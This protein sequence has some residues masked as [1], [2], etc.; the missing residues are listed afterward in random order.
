MF[1]LNIIK[2]I[3]NLSA[4]GEMYKVSNTFQ[5]NINVLFKKSKYPDNH[6]FVSRFKPVPIYV[7]LKKSRKR[8]GK[9]KHIYAR[10]NEN[11]QI[12]L[13]QVYICIAKILLEH[14]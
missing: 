8:R 13:F 9:K 14:I 1:C 3:D 7:A 10:I 4:F 2:I 5:N 11:V 6:L 12:E